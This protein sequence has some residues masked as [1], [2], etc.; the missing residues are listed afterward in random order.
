[1]NLIKSGK[2]K[3]LI[4]ILNSGFGQGLILAMILSPLGQFFIFRVY[5]CFIQLS[6]S[7]SSEMNISS[8]FHLE[9]S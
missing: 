3:D 1:M 7:F 9:S 4:Q 6:F 8:E 5:S 2:F